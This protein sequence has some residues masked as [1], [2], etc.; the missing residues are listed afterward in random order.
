MIIDN[1]FKETRPL[2]QQII[3]Y[4]EDKIIQRKWVEGE[5]IPSVRELGEKLAVNPNTCVKAYEIM[6]EKKIIEPQR[7]TGYWVCN[8]ARDKLFAAKLDEMYHKMIP[9]IILTLRKYNI[10]KNSF[11]EAINDLYDDPNYLVVIKNQT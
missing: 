10:S 11:V 3:D 9:L 2:F 8:G 7:G 6:T 4:V 5:R 1:E